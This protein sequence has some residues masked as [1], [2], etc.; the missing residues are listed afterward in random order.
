MADEGSPGLLA[1]E[2]ALCT[3]DTTAEP[4]QRQILGMTKDAEDLRVQAAATTNN[5]GRIIFI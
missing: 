5:P 1:E 2:L 3:V 4:E